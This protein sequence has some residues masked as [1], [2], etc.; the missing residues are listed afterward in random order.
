MNVDAN[1]RWMERKS[2]GLFSVVNSYLMA[3]FKV[4]PTLYHVKH[5]KLHLSL[6]LVT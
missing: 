4:E 1:S 5:R 2:H 3:H 6:L